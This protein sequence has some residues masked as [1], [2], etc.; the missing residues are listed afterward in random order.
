MKRIL[1]ITMFV[2]VSFAVFAQKVNNRGEYVVKTA[3]WKSYSGQSSFRMDLEYNSSNELSKVTK[4]Y[5]IKNNKVTEELTLKNDNGK[6]LKFI[7]YVNGKQ[8]FSAKALYNFNKNNLI[9]NIN[10]YAPSKNRLVQTFQMSYN[11]NKELVKLVKTTSENMDEDW[12]STTI[13]TINWDNGNIVSDKTIDVGEEYGGKANFV[14]YPESEVR[15]N[16]N[17]NFNFLIFY[18]YGRDY[19]SDIVF[20]T[21]WCGKNTNLILK[22]DKSSLDRYKHL[23]PEF[24]EHYEYEKNGDLIT[25]LRYIAPRVGKEHNY[26]Y[27]TL[28]LEYVY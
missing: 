4:R 26:V 5:I 18:S 27:G 8:N 19:M 9:S 28:T 21:E 25:K 23:Q 17:L 20:G 12:S 6:Y 13:T 3:I 7:R 11:E 2:C 14:Y 16:T 22:G 10:W 1:L 24:R 15:N